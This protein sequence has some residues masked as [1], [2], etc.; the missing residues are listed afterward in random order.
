LNCQYV[1]LL[2]Y[3]CIKSVNIVT[4]FA[5]FGLFDKAP[6]SVINPPI[7]SFWIFIYFDATYN[8]SK[9]LQK[10]VL[11]GYPWGVTKGQ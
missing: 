7:L 6:Y 10:S 9:Y 5:D 4:Y 3:C 2:K 1:Q 8:W 11:I